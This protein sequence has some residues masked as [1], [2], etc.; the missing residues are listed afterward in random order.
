MKTKTTVSK[1]TTKEK[2]TKIK[3]VTKSEKDAKDLKALQKKNY[4]EIVKKLNIKNPDQKDINYIQGIMK[5]KKFNRDDR[6]KL[7]RQLMD[8]EKALEAKNQPE[9]EQKPTTS[10]NPLT[11]SQM[12]KEVREDLMKLS[13]KCLAYS[14]VEGG[15][16]AQRLNL[17]ARNCKRMSGNTLRD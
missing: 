10:A 6:T 3:T 13:D 9:P 8:M 14:R 5:G 16:A 7:S 11:R 12:F 1:D 2:N 17:V 4:E 15:G